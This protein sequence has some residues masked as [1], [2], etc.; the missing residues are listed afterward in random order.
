M[1]NISTTLQPILLLH[2]FYDGRHV[3]CSKHMTCRHSSDTFETP[4]PPPSSIA[5][6]SVRASDFC[7]SEDMC[8][9]KLEH[10]IPIVF[11]D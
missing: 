1:K 5:M 4:P 10:R 11:Q 6:R 2:T 9:K 3:C 8:A 7:A